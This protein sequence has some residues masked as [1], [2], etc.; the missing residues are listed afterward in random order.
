[1][2]T[3]AL[4]AALRSACGRPMGVS[5]RVLWTRGSPDGCR[6]LCVLVG[7]SRCGRSVDSRVF[8]DRTAACLQVTSRLGR[9]AAGHAGW[10][11]FFTTDSDGKKGKREE[12]ERAAAVLK[13]K[14]ARDVETAR[15]LVSGSRDRGLLVVRWA[16]GDWDL[17]LRRRCT[18]W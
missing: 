15:N 4:S 1:M 10:Q 14:L 13:R 17:L 18:R 8:S 3:M 12:D 11:R 7:T 9:A 2:T 16:C 6:T 5:A